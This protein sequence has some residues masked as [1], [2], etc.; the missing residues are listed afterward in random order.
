MA[1]HDWNVVHAGTF[2]AFHVAWITHLS[3]ALNDGIL[4]SGYY[5]LPEQHGG[6]LIADILTLKPP[7]SGKLPPSTEGG[8]AVAQAPPR[9]QRTLS[10]SPLT[11]AGRRTVTIRHVSG[12]Q[13]IALIE[14]LSPANKDRERHV[15]ELVDKV[16]TALWQGIHVLLVDLFP[17][18][19]FDPS[20]IHAAVWERFDDHPYLPPSEEPLT[21]ASYVADS[22][23][24]A[25]LEHLKVGA[26]LSDMPLF[27]TPDR[28]VATPLEATYLAAYRGLPEYWRHEL[29]TGG[30]AGGS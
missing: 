11:R 27:L 26:T 23:P 18:G 7:G 9:V 22:L 3:E 21:L 5:S 30:R 13:V 10:A 19:R 8:L 17:P 2:H 12:H 4:P 6:R 16:C 15:V 14:I 20:G 24:Q 29:E 25:F 28:Y 1:V